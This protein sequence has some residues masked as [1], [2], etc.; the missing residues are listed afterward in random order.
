MNPEQEI[1]D[2][3]KRLKTMESWQSDLDRRLGR[4]EDLVGRME[5]RLDRAAKMAVQQLEKM[6]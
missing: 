4:Y 6:K 5:L 1:L 2:I 3:K